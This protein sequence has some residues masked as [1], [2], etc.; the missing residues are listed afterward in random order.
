MTEETDIDFD[1]RALCPDGNCTGVLDPLGACPVCGTGTTETGTGT[2]AGTG[3][4]TGTGAGTTDDSLDDERRLCP[5][6]NCV[7][8]LGPD[9]KCK[10]CG[11]L[12]NSSQ[13]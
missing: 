2:G 9:G 13:V 12:D 10:V 5:D 3:T 7:G 4:G 1:Q 11:L 6:G 8:V